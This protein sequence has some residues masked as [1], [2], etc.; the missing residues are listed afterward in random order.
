MEIESRYNNLWQKQTFQNLQDSVDY[1]VYLCIIRW[2]FKKKTITI[3]SMNKE[4]WVWVK[5]DSIF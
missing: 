5:V 3:I 4:I 1:F 2:V